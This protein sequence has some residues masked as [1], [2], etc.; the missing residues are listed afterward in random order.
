[1]EMTPI[2]HIKSDFSEKF[3]IPRQSG[4]DTVTLPQFRL[5]ARA[6][7]LRKMSLAAQDAALAAQDILD[8][9]C[10]WVTQIQAAYGALYRQGEGTEER[11]KDILAEQRALLLGRMEK[12]QRSLDR[13]DYKIAN[14]DQILRGK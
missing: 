4:A 14:Y 7:R 3:G 2:A 6:L 13:L 1:M 10:Q 8:A 5:S 11:R 9:D 12:M